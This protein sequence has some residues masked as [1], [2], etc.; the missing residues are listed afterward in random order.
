L[1]LSA[2]RSGVTPRLGLGYDSGAGNGP[3]GL[4]WTL[5]LPAIARKTDKGIPRYIDDEQADQPDVF[6]LSDA[7]DLTPALVEHNGSWIVDAVNRSEN[8]HTFR[9]VRYRP[10]VEAAFARIDRWTDVATRE[11]HWRTISRENV[12]TLYGQTPESRVADPDNPQRVFSWLICASYDD[13]GNAIL[14]RYLAE[15]SDGVDLTQANERHRVRVANRYVKQVKYGNR[16]P[17]R[18]GQWQP[19]DPRLLADSDWMFEVVFDYGEHAQDAPTPQDAGVWRCRPDPF[20]SYRAGF[21][22]RTYRLCRRVLMFHHFAGEPGVG[23]N[24]LVRSADLAYHDTPILS[25]LTSITER[26]YRRLSGGGYLA[27]A[28]PAIA[29]TYADAVID[30]QTH[31]LD[32]ESLRNLPAGVDG[33]RFH[34]IDLNGEGVAGI[35][36][37]QADTWLYKRNLSPLGAPAFAATKTIAA[38]PNLSGASAQ[39]LDLAG[40]GRPDLV[41]FDE[42]TAGFFER[43]DDDRYQW[44]P[45]QPFASRLTASTRD[46][47]LKFVDLNGDGLADVLITEQ[48]VF[49]WYPS[50]GEEGFGPA[51][52]TYPGMDEERGPTLVFAD[53][54]RTIYLA[55][56]NGDGLADLVRVRN[57]EVC[58][59]PNLGYGRFGAK[60]TMDDAPWCDAPDLF[61]Q[62]R[63]R[64]V[65]IDGTGT[66]DLIYLKND[67]TRIYANQAG[68][69]FAPA[70][71]LRGLPWLDVLTVS[72][73]SATDLFGT[74]T[75]CL[76]W[77]TPLPSGA[78][79][80][81]RYVDLMSGRKPHLLIATTNSVGVE[82]RIQYASS[83]R[84][85]L[86]DE[87]AGRPWVT[88]LP[89]PVQVVARVETFDR[90][91]GN[92]FVR[93]FAYH[94]GYFDGVE[95]EF[96]GFGLVEH[97]DTAEMATLTASGTL[98]PPT[99]FDL[100][101]DVPPT[102]TRTW[103]HTGAFVEAARITRQFAHEYY[104][105]GDPSDKVAGL[106]D[107]QLR[108]VS[109]D[110]TALP[111]T[112]RISD[113]T[114][115]A[116]ALTPEER[117]EACR[118]LRGRILR[119]EV[120]G[121]DGTDAADRPYT[122]TEYNY[123]I[124]ILQPR[125]GARHASFL[126]HEREQ[127]AFDYER[128]LIDTGGGVMRADP[129]VSHEMSLEV[130]AFGTIL[131]ELII[132]YRR[133][134]LPNV[135]LAEQLATH[136]T[137][138]ATRVANITDQ[139]TW[140]RIGV[141]VDTRTYDIVKPPDP[142]V[143]DTRVLPFGFD[144]MGTLVSTLFPL[145]I[146]EPEAGHCWPYENW[147]WRTNA[148]H[149][150]VDTRLRLIEH[151][152][153]LYRRD[154][155]TALA[156]LG[157]V[158]SLALT[159]EHYTLALT[160]TLVSSVFTL[161]ATP[162]PILE[163]HGTDDGGYVTM[164]QVWW[165]PSGRTFFSP[166]ASHTAAQELTFARQHF[167][168]S[169]RFQDPFGQATTVAYDAGNILLV[170]SSHDALHNETTAVHDYRVLQPSLVSDPNS[171]R[172]A[173]AFDARGQVVAT[174]IMG[175]ASES[176][177]DLLEG[178]DPD[179][180]DAV[181]QQFVADPLTHAAAIL[182]R[183]TS[184]I[185]YD[186]DR[187]GRCGQPPFAAMVE[188]EVHVQ[189]PGGAASPIRV[190]FTYVDGFGR[191]LQ[192]KVQA[193]DGDAPR[194][195]PAVTLPSGDVGPGALMRDGQ[196][197]LVV[198]AVTPRWVGTGRTIYNNKGKPVREYEPFFSATH[199]Y[200]PEQDMTDAGVSPVRF[201]D[202]LDRVV[203]TL[204]PNHTYQTAVT[205]AWQR[206]VSDVNDTVLRDPR[207]DP[208]AA[209]FVAG[210]FS[211]QPAGWQTWHAQRIGNQLG[212]AE[213]D[214]AQK[215]ATHAG[216]P[217]VTILDTRGRA[218]LTVIDN[219][220]DPAHQPQRYPTRTV[221]DAEGNR[222]EVVDA[223]DR[224]VMRYAFDI[225][226]RQ[227]YQA[228][229]EA[230]ERWTLPDATGSPIRG[231]DSRGLLR[232]M[233]YDELRRPIGRFVTR[234]GVQRQ[235]L[236]LVYGE[237]A[238]DA[239]NH[240]TRLQQ[241]FDGAGQV[242]HDAYDFKGNLLSTSRT[243]LVDP[244]LLPDWQTP[245]A[246]EG[247]SFPHSVTY[248][249][250]NRPITVTTPDT[251]V[252]RPTFSVAGLLERV[253]VNLRGAGAATALVTGVSY[254]AKAQRIAIAYGNGT[255]GASDYDPLTFRLTRL[256]TT[257]TANPDAFASQL[258]QNA[259]L[260]QDLHYTY[261]PIGNITRAE[262]AALQTIFH[263]GEQ[264]GPVGDYAY[265]PL[266]RLI[267][268]HGREQIAQTAISFTEPDRRDWPFAGP[269]VH[270]ADT[271]ALRNYVEQYDYDPCDNLGRVRHTA[272][273]STW[274]R[275]YDYAQASLIEPAK[276]SNRL[277]RT[278]VAGQ[279][280]TY[281]YTDAM[282]VDQLGAITAIDSMTLTWNDDDDLQS[283][284]LG[285]G[286][287]AHYQSDASGRRVRKAIRTTHGDLKSE[288][289]YLGGFEIYRE[290]NIP[291]GTIALERETLHI[292]DDERAFA[293]VET[294][295]D[296][297]TATVMRYQHGNLLGSIGV[298]L[299]EN[300][301]LIAYEEYHPFGTTAFQASRS[302]VEVTVKR[303]RYVGKE[304]DEE[305]GLYYHGARYNA[306]WLGRWTACDPSGLVDG[307]NLYAYVR[308]N[309]I[310]FVDPEGLQ[311]EEGETGKPKR[312]GA[313]GEDKKQSPRTRDKHQKA[314]ER[315][316]RE[317][318]KAQ[319]KERQRQKQQRK[320][321]PKNET[322]TERKQRE[323]QERKDRYKKESERE[324]EKKDKPDPEEQRKEQERKERERRFK[325]EERK[326]RERKEREQKEREQREREQKE[327]EQREQKEREQKDRE[328]KEREQ[329]E[330]EQKERQERERK[331]LEELDRPLERPSLAAEAFGI[332]V[333]AVGVFI[334]IRG[335]RGGGGAPEGAP[336]G[337]GGG[338][339]PAPA[340]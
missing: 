132:H 43:Q 301:A 98:P 231:W 261:D 279:T 8:G 16:T 339:Q 139:T 39:F 151:H 116:Y 1:P 117:L 225:A 159:G 257:R 92:L 213:K 127:L 143:V 193:E 108:A 182:G 167:F 157:V 211:T 332:L 169:H 264:V 234:S 146:A 118:A 140:Y 142:Q 175:K 36:S 241:V 94:H 276:M 42:A 293:L 137:L 59:W 65:D 83:T 124:E 307:I 97:W 222:R 87:R 236:R 113:G 21:E 256:K 179:P 38:R 181:L 294:R 90:V 88:R 244:T 26:G 160:P 330:K 121:L 200:E 71:L 153:T 112:I 317:Q 72:S 48:D 168:L 265:D 93:L 17:N 216:T 210:Y 47:N 246:L 102:L 203:V 242:V 314:D 34:W 326:A 196:G 73:V 75:A 208:D 109:L 14:Y 253:D 145:D 60:V 149:A 79:R 2:G 186:P 156:P 259:T 85:A 302:A 105:E 141:P 54:T 130:D 338:W 316:I 174:A 251:S 189:D 64:L 76:V 288:R 86:Q 202:A 62:R 334:I 46:P 180:T 125:A 239:K 144:Q 243:L 331:R 287:T 147:D 206:I 262:D 183:A 170:T 204:N 230:G 104:R 274:T 53:D 78:G 111:A 128:Q 269:K 205:D 122:T 166:E 25:T 15:N 61:D 199:L 24:C 232:R 282:G 238:G 96:R 228:G 3:F 292:P 320:R 33:Q 311:G 207:T 266:Y 164:D 162:A 304:R 215:A 277:T 260:V 324:Q 185:V 129:R 291:A 45:F 114:R 280:E 178:F 135:T 58:Y 329:K 89:F 197:A 13:K 11:T 67:G 50:H 313:H 165:I 220:P 217:T 312:K 148:A 258:F 126:S 229:M 272:A 267:E 308:N 23:L 103:F 152:R 335:A 31:V 281:R 51:A 138:H 69:S 271:Q 163:G 28:F 119:Q 340:F 18:D 68:N 30:E 27:R 57:G 187:F 237:A 133:R 32:P 95:R 309:S 77:S 305:T 172:T 250:L 158:E 188:R 300:G 12:T 263:G 29:L 254:N 337:P 275:T 224:I 289:R 171:N 325:E 20:S 131:R 99:N 315:G 235:S 115:A 223:R 101:S 322:D 226:G 298:E 41:I 56:M 184:R 100:A 306:P 194:R 80:Q 190:S 270:P 247:H 5:S 82:T 328:Q 327:R 22:I 285:G 218:F 123:T 91:S 49:T 192:K 319:E 107:D 191:D 154:D 255:T 248:D 278:Q 19:T 221:L 44:S 4:G 323:N 240:R 134:A 299:D 201:Y 318:K 177:G 176:L 63:V 173:V 214:A 9:V 336:A 303:Y 286:G 81:M 74:G 6:I 273:G 198:G 150:P 106:T 219:G 84:F 290:F 245:P 136:L 55:D 296:G 249:A 37:E 66:A 110:D 252:Y 155:L 35:L 333:L 284:D 321:N 10:R 227:L 295:T 52:R 212:A 40:G 283:V 161:L 70:H 120:Y 297:A 7:E 195:Q 233:T 268:A 310:R 209:G